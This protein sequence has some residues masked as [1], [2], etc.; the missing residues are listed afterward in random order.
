MPACLLARCAGI[1]DQF[2]TNRDGLLDRQE[3][4]AMIT[5]I[6]NSSAANETYLGGLMAAFASFDKNA[7]GIIDR[8]GE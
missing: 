5:A 8:T 4:E 6:G 2:D 3:V 7:D 1:F